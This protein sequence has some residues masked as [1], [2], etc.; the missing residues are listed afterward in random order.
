MTSWSPGFIQRPFVFTQ[1]SLSVP[2]IHPG[3]AT[4]HLV[5]ASLYRHGSFSNFPCFWGALVGY[6]AGC[7]FTRICWI[8]VSLKIRLGVWGFW[9][10]V[11]LRLFLGNSKWQPGLPRWLAHKGQ[12]PAS[13]RAGHQDR[14][15]K[16][17]DCLWQGSALLLALESLMQWTLW[18]FVE[19]IEAILSPSSMG[20]A[21]S[22]WGGVCGWAAPREEGC[23][24]NPRVTSQRT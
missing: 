17:T 18:C 20:T 8:P 12:T 10:G 2:G 9:A 1:H 4:L 24:H 3:Y 22:F 15:G 14:P 11:C 19:E 5:T 13:P 7:L 23:P 6:I 21:L 16:L